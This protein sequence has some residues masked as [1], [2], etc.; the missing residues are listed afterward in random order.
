MGLFSRKPSK[1]EAYEIQA[2]VNQVKSL[3]KSQYS[4][5]TVQLYAEGRQEI[6]DT[7]V[8]LSRYE[9]KYPH[10]FLKGQHPSD[11][12]QQIEDERVVCEHK[13]VDRILKRVERL[14]LEYK[15]P[16]GKQNNLKKELDLVAYY[17]DALLPETITYLNAKAA[18]MFPDYIGG[19]S[20]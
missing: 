9:K 5:A 8:M 17:S 4:V 13:L 20:C 12:M 1:S 2:G 15:T 18:K 16:R 6:V 7:L 14:L 3:Y 11:I 19:A 10:V